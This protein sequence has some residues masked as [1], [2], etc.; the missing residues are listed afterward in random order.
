MVRR[1]PSHIYWPIYLA[2]V[3]WFVLSG[4]HFLRTS[5]W[6]PIGCMIVLDWVM[7][8]QS[9]LRFVFAAFLMLGILGI[10]MAAILLPRGGPAWVRSAC[11]VGALLASFT[12]YQILLWRKILRGGP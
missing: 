7:T 4:F 8:R 6:M 11:E 2:L 9:V 12:A 1:L 10:M 5:I 3:L